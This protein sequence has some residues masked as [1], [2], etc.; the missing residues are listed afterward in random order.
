MEQT[1][2]QATHVPEIEMHQPSTLT[3]RAA[4]RAS[5][6]LNR[7]ATARP[8]GFLAFAASVEHGLD[9]NDPIIKIRNL[10]FL[11][12]LSSLFVIVL[13]VIPVVVSLP[14]LPSSPYPRWY[15]VNDI[16]RLLEPII[17]LPFQLLIF[18][19]AED[20]LNKMSAGKKTIVVTF[21]A[22]FVAIY[23]QGAGFHSAATMFKNSIVT[24][25]NQ[26]NSTTLFPIITEIYQWQRDTWEHRVAHY[27]YASGGILLSFLFAFLF[28]DFGQP[29]GVSDKIARI[30]WGLSSLLYG[31]VIGAVAIQFPS[32]SIVALVLILVYGFGILGSF[33]YTK[34]VKPLVFGTRIVV[35]FYI[36]SYAIAFIIVLIWI[37]INNGDATVSRND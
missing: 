16:I 11:F 29:E 23:Q 12:L 35:Q 6:M 32:G 36:L 15:G 3:A 9:K 33:M 37:A 2:E 21:F 10:G 14:T 30:V 28:Q 17:A 24:L 18:L 34:E 13:T 19:H 25:K 20:K 4:N 22:V 5:R 31:I 26:D 7:L 1:I 27:I 8:D